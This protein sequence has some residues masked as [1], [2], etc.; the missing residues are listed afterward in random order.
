MGINTDI[1]ISIEICINI[2]TDIGLDIDTRYS[3]RRL[4]EASAAAAKYLDKTYTMQTRNVCSH[5]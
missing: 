5:I 2:D 1:G 4:Y 3:I